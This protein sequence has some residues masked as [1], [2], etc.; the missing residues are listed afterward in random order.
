[1][2]KVGTGFLEKSRTEYSAINAAVSLMAQM[3][4][5]LT[6]FVNRI[7][8][9]R[10]L[11]E[12]YVGINGLFLNILNILS[13]SELGIGAAITYA[14][15]RPVAE[16]DIPRQKALMGVYRRFYR[17]VAAVILLL[18]LAV[19]PFMD[20]LMK[21]RP[22]VEHLTF[23]Y[24]LYLANA[25]LSYLLV[26]KRVMIEVCQKSYIIT[27]Y[28]T[29]FLVLQNIVQIVILEISGNFIVFLIVGICSTLL[30][31]LS[32]S[33][34]AERMFPYLRESSGERLNEEDR[35]ALSRNIRASLLHRVGGVVVNHTDNLVLSA[36][37]GVVS[38]GVYSNYFL[39]IG[40]VRQLLDRIFQGI[41]ASVGN[42]G[43]TENPQRVERVYNVA[44]F[45]GQWLYGIC[46]VCLYE[47]L[48]PFIELFFGKQYLFEK[49]VVFILC[50]VFFLLGTRKTFS[51]FWSSLGL[52]WID[53]YKSLAEAL[54]NIVL[55]LLLVQCWG[56]FGVFAGTVLSML[57]LALWL[58]PWLFHR[59]YLH[60]QVGPFI[61]RQAG[62]IAVTGLVWAAVDGLCSLVTGPLF[63]VLVIRA[64]ICGGLGNLLL[65]LF[66]F[67]KKE[68]QSAKRRAA[69]LL[70]KY[71]GSIGRK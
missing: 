42:L 22:N 41:A 18:G 64:F 28:T 46:A 4:A 9:V 24:L 14:L 52:F 3:V 48:N 33:K 20:V 35:Q 6:G 56:V 68:F 7:V 15:Y 36:F 39:L 10:N 5:I 65:L 27:L 8:F 57:P 40:S 1:M 31:N 67:R 58:E 47:L 25:A 59:F 43:A 11:S 12:G 66:Y 19:I 32:I 50:M 21:E 30:G 60:K 44:F 34:K 62:Y 71:L 17:I 54:V 45:I 55:S 63:Q 49:P 51:I 16:G 70:R 69:G 37:V 29:F 2:K 23:I 26:Y 38:V 53:R 13:L 61:R